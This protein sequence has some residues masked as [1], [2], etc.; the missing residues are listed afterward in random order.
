MQTFFVF[1]ISV[2]HSGIFLWSE[3]LLQGV[4]A[5]SFR[6]GQ[7]VGGETPGDRAAQC[8]AQRVRLH[9]VLPL[10]GLVPGTSITGPSMATVKLACFNWKI[11]LVNIWVHILCSVRFPILPSSYTAVPNLQVSMLVMELIN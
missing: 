8:W 9:H 2:V 7:C 6:W 10:P 1:V 4:G 5:W 3:W 11:C